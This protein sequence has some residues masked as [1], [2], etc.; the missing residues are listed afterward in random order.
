MLLLGFADY[1]EPAKAL[2]SKLKLP[3]SLVEVHHF[4]D[5]ESKVTLPVSIS[6]TVIICRSLAQPNDKLIELMLVCA[7]AR[8]MGA[9]RLIL[10][11]PYLCYMRQDKAFN[12]GEAISQQI[13]GEFLSHYVD[14]L[15]TVDPHLH[16]VSRLNSVVKLE[17]AI[18]LQA[19]QPMGEFLNE[20]FTAPV[21]IG[22]DEES[23]Q[24]VSAIAG[25]HGWD[26]LVAIKQRFGDRSVKVELD[27]F[28]F[29]DR[30][31]VIVDDIASTGNTLIKTAE[32]LLSKHP[33]SLSILVTH[34]FFVDKALDKL[35]QLGVR[36]IWSS[37]SVLHSTNAFSL[38]DLLAPNIEN[39]L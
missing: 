32:L 26:F 1:L 14:D 24:W 25:Q 8:K 37:D 31:I 2:A 16:R 15:I 18:S 17:N 10:V 9:K 33:E 3:F 7:T 11:A 21:I 39:I 28:D 35:E 23:R 12:P 5:G 22:P 19:T 38:V 29:I 34:A 36:N 20:K 27:D 6:D 30:D 4:P 13:I